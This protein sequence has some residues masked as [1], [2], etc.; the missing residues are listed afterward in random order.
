MRMTRENFRRALVSLVTHGLSSRR[1]VAAGEIDGSTP[2]FESGLIDS[3]AVLELMAFVEQATGRPIPGRMVHMKHFGT[4]DRICAA[5]WP[6]DQ[7][8]ERVHR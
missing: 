4:I 7:E 3:L 8:V 1:R 5:F 6:A 2:L